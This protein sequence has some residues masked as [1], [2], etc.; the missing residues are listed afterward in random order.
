MS[1]LVSL[2]YVCGLCFFFRQIFF[3][4]ARYRL[5]CT[6]FEAPAP[7][8]TFLY[9]FVVPIHVLVCLFFCHVNIPLWNVS[10]YDVP[11]DSNPLLMSLS[12]PIFCMPLKM[13]LYDFC[14][15]GRFLPVYCLFLGIL[16]H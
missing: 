15:L 10:L 3:C 7:I 5:R 9:V 8:T 11:L 12:N 14:F 4:G 13:V 2:Y 1:V 16:P 6:H